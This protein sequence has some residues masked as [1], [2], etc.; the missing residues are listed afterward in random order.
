MTAPPLVVDTLDEVVSDAGRVGPVVQPHADRVPEP[1]QE[2]DAEQREHDR[3]DGRSPE[4]PGERQRFDVLAVA[5][6]DAL[7]PRRAVAVWSIGARIATHGDAPDFRQ[8]E[9][10]SQ[11]DAALFVRLRRSLKRR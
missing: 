5:F 8:P 9:L 3:D 6:A 10:S 1:E 11:H 7:V 2:L 4:L